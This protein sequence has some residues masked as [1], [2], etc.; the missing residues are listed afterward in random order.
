M[1]PVGRARTSSRPTLVF[2]RR[3]PQRLSS[4]VSTSASRWGPRSSAS[5]TCTCVW[6]ITGA[7]SVMRAGKRSKQEV[8]LG[9]RQDASRLTRQQL[10]VGAHLVRLGIDLDARHQAVVHHVAL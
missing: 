4:A 6:V 8:A 1:L 9:H 10:A 7:V 3:R 2:T 5:W